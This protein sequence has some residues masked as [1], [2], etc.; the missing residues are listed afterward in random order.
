[1]YPYTAGSTSLTTLLPPWAL[2]GGISRTLK[3]LKEPKSRQRIKEELGHEHEAWDNL[4]AST[5][6]DNVY[7]SSLSNDGSTDLEG[8]NISEVSESR[9]LDPADCM[10]DLLL[11]QDGKVSIVFFHM[12]ETDVEQVLR[13]D[14]SLIASDSLHDQARKP[15]PRLY[16]TFPHVLARYVR[17]KKLL[18]LEE[19]IRKMTSFPARRFRLG[20]R[21]LIAPGY[22]ADLVVFHPDEISDKATYDDPKNFPEGI[23]HVLVN[24]AQVLVSGVHR[25]ARA[26]RAIEG[27]SS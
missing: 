7:I 8:K 26:G 4:L 6:W 11:E 3:R 18:T 14:R 13:W 9:G 25:D 2:E 12:T 10:M 23:S 17:E 15:H 16:G 24:G 19:A 27:S 21:G 22:A 5:G 20:K 1:V